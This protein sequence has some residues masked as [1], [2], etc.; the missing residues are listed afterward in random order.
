V[1]LTQKEKQSM[2]VDGER[3]LG[4]RGDEERNENSHQVW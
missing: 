3:E 2:E 1:T 4:G